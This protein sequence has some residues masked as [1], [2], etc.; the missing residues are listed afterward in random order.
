MLPDSKFQ[1]F[2]SSSIAK[3][4][5]FQVITDHVDTVGE[6]KPY[7]IVITMVSEP[8]PIKIDAHYFAALPVELIFK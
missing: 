6:R 3:V 4:S 1:P 2:E 7:Y 5:Y 8:W